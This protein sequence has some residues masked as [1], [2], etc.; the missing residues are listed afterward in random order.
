MTSNNRGMDDGERVDVDAS[1]RSLLEKLLT[2]S[3]R[4]D[5]DERGALMGSRTVGGRAPL[6][7]KLD[8][9]SVAALVELQVFRKA[10]AGGEVGYTFD[11][12]KNTLLH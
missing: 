2:P 7:R 1:A 11:I 12:R 3:T 5:R 9:E 10:F 6:V 8:P 4:R